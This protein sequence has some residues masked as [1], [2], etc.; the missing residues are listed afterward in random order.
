MDLPPDRYVHK[1]QT[2]MHSPPS[3]AAVYDGSGEENETLCHAATDGAAASGRRL[4][5]PAADEYETKVGS[6][7]FLAESLCTDCKTVSPTFKHNALD[8]LIIKYQIILFV[9]FR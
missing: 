6:P 1:K 8:I 7:Y 9:E 4:L 2:Q 5:P 3:P